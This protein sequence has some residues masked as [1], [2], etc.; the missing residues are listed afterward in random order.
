MGSAAF[1][2]GE[3]CNGELKKKS[4]LLICWS[5]R[6]GCAALFIYVQP[7]EFDHFDGST[8]KRKRNAKLRVKYFPWIAIGSMRI[9]I[10]INLS[11]R[12][13]FLLVEKRGR[14]QCIKVLHFIRCTKT[15]FSSHTRRTQGEVLC[16]FIYFI[17]ESR[18]IYR[19]K[20]EPTRPPTTTNTKK[21]VIKHA[22][23][24]CKHPQ[25]PNKKR[26]IN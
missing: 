9:S 11:G 6:C 5:T 12:S 24:Q 16:S 21:M 2:V 1:V 10:S 17:E 3:R 20:S 8:N 23:T 26:A 15:T 19:H 25:Q 18:Y 4:I 7:N 14:H 22:T 13:R